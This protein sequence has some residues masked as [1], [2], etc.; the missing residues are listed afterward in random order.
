M[1]RLQE[2]VRLHRRGYGAREVA[3][4]LTMSPNTEREY[5]AAL[6][7]A[8]LLWGPAED[9]PELDVLCAAVLA[10]RPA[11]STP[12]H[13]LSRIERWRPTIEKHSKDGLGPQ[14]IFDRLRVE[15]AAD[16][17]GSYAQVKR[18]CRSIRRAHPV[19]PEDVAI[20]VVTTPGDIAQVDFGY[21]GQ[22]YDP[23]QRMLRKAWCFVMVLAHSRR[24]VVRVVFDQRAETW[25]AL[26]VEAFA[27]LGAVPRTIVPDNLK[28][29]VIR[30]AF[31]ARDSTA[32][33][34]RSYVD[35]AR[36]YGFVVDPTPPRSPEKKGRVE[37]GV[38]YVKRN[39]FKARNGQNV[40]DVRRELQRWSDTIA[41]ERIHGT[42]GQKP[43]V[44]FEADERDAMLPLPETRFELSSW[45]KTTVRDDAH[46]Y[47]GLRGYS[48]P[49]R[50]VGRAVWLN[51]RET[52]VRVFDD[53]ELVATHDRARGAGRTTLESHLPEGRRDL[54]HRSRE[55]WE[56]RAAAIGP[57][58]AYLIE[59]VFD[60]DTALSQLPAVQQIVLLL[61]RLPPERA[62]A[63][64]RRASF[65]GATKPAAIER[66]LDKGLDR[67]PLPTLAHPNGTLESPRF[68]RPF[69]FFRS[70]ARVPRETH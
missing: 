45:R 6:I 37:S 56:E 22:L 70:S 19:S 4:L 25:L 64:S 62:N 32:T 31:S 57:E 20:P 24:M 55:H 12:G 3:R 38:K 33:L 39:F 15:H 63:I 9:L 66:I 26:H 29:A 65:Y 54:R 30:A 17:A 1:H 46:A 23:T 68:A 35:L 18:M 7:D 27:E 59:E 40:D 61:E 21:V 51:L 52:S 58:T 69:D 16:F 13:E 2:M 41:N 47:D 60:S 5:R 42:T 11:A 36:H 67:E 50:L 14:A 49:F 53:F 34:H 43:S 44:L 28:A 10:R 48:V 8:G